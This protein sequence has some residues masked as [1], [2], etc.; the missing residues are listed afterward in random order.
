MMIIPRPDGYKLDSRPQGNEEL[1]NA[2][3]SAALARGQ[4]KFTRAELD[5]FDVE[6]LQWESVVNADGH[7]FS[8]SSQASN[9]DDATSG[10]VLEADGVGMAALRD[11]HTGRAFGTLCSGGQEGVGACLMSF[12][13]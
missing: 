8:P 9:L 2:D 7:W 10:H 3:L 12:C 11:S 5:A 13:K 1:V 6:G 4:L